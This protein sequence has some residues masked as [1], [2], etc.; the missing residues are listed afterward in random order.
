MTWTD[1]SGKRL[2]DYPHPSLAV[3]VALLTVRYDEEGDAQLCV[4]LLQH[5]DGRWS[6]PGSFVREGER[7]VEAV[8]RTV[9]GKLGIATRDPRQLR[10]FDDPARDSR[11]HVVS[12]AHADLL[13]E[14]A[15]VGDGRAVLAPV[16]R[17]RARVSGR[18]RL[19]YDHDEIV[20]HAV[21]WAQERYGRRPDPSRLLPE[22]FTL[23]EL[24]LLHEAVL[25]ERIQKD[26]FR[27]AMLARLEE[28]PERSSGGPGRPAAKY[29]HAR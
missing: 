16:D 23:R 22:P 8:R 20:E 1:S 11:G 26:N 6:L 12:V 5:D 14:A 15:L 21:A 4:A 10:I 17:R 19:L 2:A 28:L 7:L 9:E 18:G 29:R 25:G 3:D 13:P 27:R 24:R